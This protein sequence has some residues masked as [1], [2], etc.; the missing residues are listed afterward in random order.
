MSLKY[1]VTVPEYE[2]SINN[3]T[4]MSNLL[5]SRIDKQELD[6]HEHILS[7]GLELDRLEDELVSFTEDTNTKFKRLKLYIWLLLSG[8]V[9]EG[10]T[11]VVLLCHILNM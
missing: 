5:S 11:I 3:L 9:V 4:F 8:L 2:N 1:T 6:L 7:N 10:S